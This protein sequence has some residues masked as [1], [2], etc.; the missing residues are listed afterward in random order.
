MTEP[1]SAVPDD[2]S[3]DA[4]E[5]TAT[6]P[7]RRRP[8]AILAGALTVLLAVAGVTAAAAHKRVSVDVD[9]EI[10]NVST[11]A[12]SVEGA[13]DEAGVT[14]GDHDL[15]VPSPDESLS[16]GTEIVV[17]TAEQVSFVVDGEPT[18]LWTIGRTAE[19][20]LADVS[21]SG[22]D[23]AMATS[24]S[25]DGRPDLD[26]PLVTDG[27]VTFV[28]DSDEKTV[29][30]D[31]TVGLAQ[32]LEQADIELGELDTVS[33][34]MD[35]DGTPLVTITRIS[36][37]EKKTTEKVPFKTETRK[38]D[39]RYEGESVVV[40]AG[41][42][43]VRTIVTWQRKVDGEVVKE[44]ERSN[45]VTTEPVTKIVEVGTK[46]RP[47]PKPAPKSDG[48]GSS[49][50]GGGSA[51]AGVWA[52]LAQ[53][54]S[55]GNPSAVSASGTYHGLYQFSVATWQA[56]GGTGLPSQASAAEQTKRAKILQ[57]RSGWGQWP[58]CAAKLGL[59]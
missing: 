21:S 39:E 18:E 33:V 54:E 37:D 29:T 40:Q 7:R 58:A 49:S 13:L 56:V 44:E 9:G 32:A 41:K 55:G 1:L 46:E 48:G 11:F 2:A 16:D 34:S 12:G 35:E 36:E 28:V 59:I 52:K 42:D 27:D 38:T 6:K 14:P 30:M 5:A 10:Q 4:P 25:S 45:K 57:A 24:R 47:A 50:S 20:A 23:I 15:V 22:R 51:P 26:L 19:E 43:G 8:V 53:C 31:G 3:P 17:R